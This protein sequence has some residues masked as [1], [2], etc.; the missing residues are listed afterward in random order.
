MKSAEKPESIPPLPASDVA[1]SSGIDVSIPKSVH[2]GQK[3][4]KLFD[5]L[6]KRVWAIRP[7]QSLAASKARGFFS[8]EE[9]ELF[10]RDLELSRCY[11]K[12]T[13]LPNPRANEPIHRRPAA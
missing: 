8:E 5:K 10:S 3:F 4:W 6:V 1:A 13:G 11:G 9:K 12:L 7:G 2:S